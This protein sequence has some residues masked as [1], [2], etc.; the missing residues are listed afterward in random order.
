MVGSQW[1]YVSK[2][3]WKTA[4][5]KPKQSE[6]AND[7]VTDAVTTSPKKK[8]PKQFDGVKSEEPFVKTRKKSK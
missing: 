2:S 6:V 5:R 4:T 1:A 7:Q 8:N 3:E